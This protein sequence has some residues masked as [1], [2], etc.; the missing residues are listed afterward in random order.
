MLHEWEQ[1]RVIRQSSAAAVAG[2]SLRHMR[3]L[4]H[5]L[6]MRNNEVWSSGEC[7]YGQFLGLEIET[8]EIV[9]ECEEAVHAYPNSMSHGEAYVELLIEGA[10]D[11]MGAMRER[12]VLNQL[13]EGRVHRIDLCFKAMLRWFPFYVK[14]KLVT[15]S[16]QFV[17]FRRV[18][19]A[20][21]GPE[22]FVGAK[23][24]S[25]TNSSTAGA[26]A[27]AASSA[28][29][30]QLDPEV[31]E[32]LGKA[33]MT[34][35]RTRLAL[36]HCLQDGTLHCA[37]RAM[38]IEGA[39]VVVTL[40]IAIWLFLQLRGIFD[41][42]Q[43]TGFELETSS[44]RRLMA[45]TTSFL[46]DQAVWMGRFDPQA[47]EM[48][49]TEEPAWE[50]DGSDAIWLL[51]DSQRLFL[52][53]LQEVVLADADA[54]SHLPALVQRIVQYVPCH[55]GEGLP[56]YNTSLIGLHT[57]AISN[58]L[59]LAGSDRSYWWSGS[60]WALAYGGRENLVKI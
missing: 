57:L 47:A 44:N 39:V 45:A 25:S 52:E 58:G 56:P 40:A 53:Y 24:Q 11:F 26:S 17:G 19:S 14:E 41:H 42:H 29:E 13:E 50:L 38:V 2:A 16:G 22:P 55:H 8:A 15:P 7:F 33:L 6:I 54:Y 43:K 36:Q 1:V 10:T 59:Q 3:D 48:D 34:H 18:G 31:E 32:N 5:E 4:R 60:A 49:A 35:W 37:A 12:N 51:R 28:S 27:T 30:G 46:L 9:A 21:E 23:S 20:N